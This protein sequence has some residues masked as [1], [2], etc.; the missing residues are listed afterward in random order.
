MNYTP[1]GKLVEGFG[2]ALFSIH[3]NGQ[4]VF[5]QG[6]GIG[7]VR[8][9]PEDLKQQGDGHI[10]DLDSLCERFGQ[11]SRKKLMEGA[12]ARFLFRIN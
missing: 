4:R 10:L 8:T 11:P 7:S 9:P 6:Q 2:G 3:L 5:A 12:Q 1:D